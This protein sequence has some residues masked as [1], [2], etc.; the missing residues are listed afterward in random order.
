MMVKEGELERKE[1][2]NSRRNFRPIYYL[3]TKKGKKRYRLK[4][5]LG[6]L[7]LREKAYLL[8]LLYCTFR[9]V[10]V[11]PLDYGRN[12]LENE[13]QLDRFLSEIH[14][15]RKDFE[16]ERVD[17]NADQYRVIEMVE[18]K[19]K[20][21]ILRIQYLE[22]SNELEGQYEY[23]YILPGISIR[24]FLRGIK[25]GLALEYITQSMSQSET[26]EC[27]E[28]LLKEGLITIVMRYRGEPRYDIANEDIRE[29]LKSC[30]LLCGVAEAAMN[31]MW[32]Y[33]RPPRVEER[34]WLEMLRGKQGAMIY[35]NKCYEKLK[36]R[37]KDKKKKGYHKIPSE[38]ESAIKVWYG[39]IITYYEEIN[40]NCAFV[41]KE[42]T[43]PLDILIK[44]VYPEFLRNLVAKKEI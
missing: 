18:P 28:L 22:G 33:A 5:H 9:E 6:V 19:Q 39:R 4:I 11:L 12:V 34:K 35:L 3:Q 17:F 42:L 32:K 8:L 38:A 27:F 37:E 24:Q 25:G 43:A 23:R 16:V 30:W 41:S 26:E 20:V 21:R 10:P 40:K 29:V 31:F 14:L 15:C 36:A 1:L 13:E 7:G 2:T 44:M